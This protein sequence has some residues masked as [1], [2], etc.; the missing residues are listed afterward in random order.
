MD[1]YLQSRLHRSFP[2]GLMIAIVA[3][4]TGCLDQR[5]ELGEDMPI[6]GSANPA[7]ALPLAS[8]IWTVEDALNQM[9]SLDWEA[10]ALSGTAMLVQPFDLLQAPPIDLPVINEF[11]SETFTLDAS[12][13]QGLS[14]LPAGSELTLNHETAWGWELPSMDTVDS[15]WVDEGMLSVSIS[16]DIPMDHSFEIVCTNLYSNGAPIVLEVDMAYLGALPFDASVITNTVDARGVFGITD[17]IEVLFDWAIVMTSTGEAVPE[18]AAISIEVMWQD[19]EVSG[20]FGKF[21]SQTTMDFEVAQAL[22]L[23]TEWNPDQLHFADPRIRLHARNSSGIPIGIEWEQFAFTTDQNTWSVGGPDIDD[24]PILTAAS[25]PD[26]WGETTHVIDNTGTTPTLTEALELRP[27]S[28]KLA[29]EILL[30]PVGQNSSFLTSESTLAIEGFLEIPL[31]GWGRGLTWRD[32]IEGAISQELNAGINPPLDWQDVESIT[33]RFIASNGWPLGME[34]QARFL[35]SDAVAIDSLYTSGDADSFQIPSGAVDWSVPV[36][37]AS[38]GRVNQA[39]E[40]I[41]DLV[42]TREKAIALLA[43]DCR[44]IEVALTLGTPEAETDAL[45]RFFPEDE[46]SLKVSARVDCSITLAP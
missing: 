10:D 35:D 14:S 40:T 30:N 24:F 12:T 37:D 6:N 11:L 5:F 41:M 36:T 18:D 28:A 26:S 34:M 8:G 2:L 23:S 45:V 38:H 7:F 19:V 42:L 44:G 32:T 13:A 20:A 1:F 46:L 9:D 4:L 21:A 3:V 39:T 17:G 33:V 22:P 25:S 43:M 16:S 15:L 31:M 27:D 29:G